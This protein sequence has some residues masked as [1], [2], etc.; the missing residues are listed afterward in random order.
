V[1]SRDATHALDR[2]IGIDVHVVQMLALAQQLQ[3]SG[4]ARVRVFGGQLHRH[5]R[6]AQ[7]A[8]ATIRQE[9]KVSSST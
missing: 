2:L 8:I 6:G 4:N 7:C 1:D 3:A 5:A 9:L